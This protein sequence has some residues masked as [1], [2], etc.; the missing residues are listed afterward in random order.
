MKF[1]AEIRCKTGIQGRGTVPIG[2]GLKCSGRGFSLF[3]KSELMGSG[4]RI[5]EVVRAYA[6]VFDEGSEG[7]S[8]EMSDFEASGNV[9]QNNTSIRINDR[10]ALFNG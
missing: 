9:L 5:Q 7:K 3:A 2:C 1:H 4:P 10:N 6:N 8:S